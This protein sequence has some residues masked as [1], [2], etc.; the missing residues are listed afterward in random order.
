MTDYMGK[1]I[2]AGPW[3]GEFGWE[4]FAWQ[5]YLRAIKKQH[6]LKI[7]IICK[8][9]S[10]Q[11]Y[12]DFAEE[13]I[14]YDPP[15]TGLSDSFFKQGLF[16]DRQLLFT[17]L[18]K[19]KNKFSWLPP[20]RIGTP[21][22]TN[23]N[24]NVEV[25]PFQVTP[26]YI[27]YKAEMGKG[28]RHDIIVHARNRNL[29]EQDNWSLANWKTLIGLLEND[30]SIACVGS[31]TESLALPGT[32]DFRGCSLKETC[33]L[34]SDARIA[35]G[36]SSGPMHLASLCE[37]SHLVWGSREMSQYRYENTWNPLNT[38]VEFLDK[39]GWHPPP[40]FIYEKV[41]ESVI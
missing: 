9:G 31:T 38:K 24:D 21:P 6:N 33:Q 22:Y 41:L 28:K 23:W 14:A 34:L 7:V 29:R 4:L 17:I 37:C 16:L 11:L 35:I 8:P 1:T 19:R 20:R 40:E 27:S 2:V 25:G 13:I 12:E 5:G 3:V 18:G 30:F 39:Y 32:T 36:P 10:E 15:D 26:E